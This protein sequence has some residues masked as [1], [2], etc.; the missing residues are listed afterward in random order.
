MDVKFMHCISR[1]E[2]WVHTSLTCGQR[3]DC[4]KS[5]AQRIGS[6]KRRVDFLQSPT[7]QSVCICEGLKCTYRLCKEIGRIKWKAWNVP[8]KWFVIRGIFGNRMMNKN[9]CRVFKHPSFKTLLFNN[10]AHSMMVSTRFVVISAPFNTIF[11]PNQCRKCKK[12]C[13][14]FLGLGK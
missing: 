10:L 5:S 9:V 2:R 4:V 11:H 8:K 7:T 3:Q 14:S 12:A 13:L 1:V 6:W